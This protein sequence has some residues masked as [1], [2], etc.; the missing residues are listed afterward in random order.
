[1]TVKEMSDY[2][3]QA[4]TLEGI[5]KNQKSIG[6][7]IRSKVFKYES[8]RRWD[9]MSLTYKITYIKSDRNDNLLV[10]IK[11]SGTMGRSWRSKEN[12]CVTEYV[13]YNHTTSRSRNNDIR[14]AV[15]NDVQK[16]FRLFGVDAHKVEIGKIKVCKVL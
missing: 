10:N 3:N 1:M 15:R 12:T 13:K 4:S 2:F 8:T 11:V 7:L 5:Y 16:F 6:R 9:P 14:R